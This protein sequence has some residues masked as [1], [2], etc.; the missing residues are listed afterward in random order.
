MA[1][2]CGFLVTWVPSDPGVLLIQQ[3]RRVTVRANHRFVVAN[4]EII[5]SRI[6][7]LPLHYIFVLV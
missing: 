4:G 1:A 3:N 6:I 7:M 2:F 5:I